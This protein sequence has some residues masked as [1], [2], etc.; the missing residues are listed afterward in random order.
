MRPLGTTGHFVSAVT[1]GTTPLGDLP[2][3]TAAALVAEV[4]ASELRTIDTSN[5]YSGGRTEAVLGR[6]VAEEGGLPPQGLIITK[7]DASGRDYSGARVRASVNESMERLNLDHFPLIH[8]HDPEF[9]DFDDI[10]APGGAVDT[11]VSLRDE[12]V[13]DAIGVA[14]GDVRVIQRYVDLGVF[15]ALLVHNRLTIADRSADQ[16]VDQ[17]VESGMTVFNAA[18]F[19]GGLLA[20]PRAGIMNY[21]YRPAT[22]ELLR[23]VSMMA[24][25]ADEYEVD[26][27]TIALQESIR[28]PRVTS[29]IVGLSKPERVR[30]TVAAAQRDL[31]EELFDRIHA[32]MP[33]ATAWLDA[34]PAA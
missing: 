17:A 9:F 25:V 7:A 1:F 19:G 2:G 28:D 31:P 15:D 21:G 24:D 5:G 22:P 3:Q 16:L 33:P 29:T 23:S 20:A 12:G 11:L 26:L 27:A 6:L 13:V 34:P 4:L 18:V 30:S 10:T 8:L 14:G 32:L